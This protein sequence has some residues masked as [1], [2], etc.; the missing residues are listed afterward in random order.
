MHSGTSRARQ[1]AV[2]VLFLLAFGILITRLLYLQVIRHAFYSKLASEQHNVSVE[3][4]AKRG[5]IFDRRM[6]VLAVNLN[7]DSIFANPRAVKNKR[8]AAR[9]LSYILK[10]NENVILQKLSRDKGFIWIKRKIA[11]VEASQVKS[12]KVEGIGVIKESK[13]LFQLCLK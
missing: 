3:I 13:R 2:V 5:T 4:P 11:G 6:R 10:L 7:S 9:E 12:L 8:F 1:I